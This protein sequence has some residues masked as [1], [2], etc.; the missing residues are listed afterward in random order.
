M[1]S[2]GRCCHEL[3]VTDK[4][5][6][7]RIIYRGDEDAIVIGDVFAKKSRTTPREVIRRCR[8]RLAAYDRAGRE[9]GTR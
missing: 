3:R 1:S 4:G 9:T 6:E 7:W 8:K 5:H 2:I